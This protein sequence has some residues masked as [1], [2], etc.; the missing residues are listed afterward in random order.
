MEPF[1]IA[2]DMDGT[3][4]NDKKKI[5]YRTKRYL[6]S[7]PKQGHKIVLASGRPSR[8]LISYHKELK[9]DTP[10][11][12]YNGA[13]VFSLTDNDFPTKAFEFPKEIVKDV[14]LKL[15]PYSLNTMC[16]TD[17]EIWVDRA[18]LYLAKFFWYDNMDIIYG[19]LDKT[20]DKN[21]MTMIVQTPEEVKDTKAIT[22][23]VKDYPDLEIRFWTGS[24]YFELF[25]KNI[26]KG[27]AVKLI[28][29]YYHIPKDRIIVFGDAEND[30]EMFL[31]AGTAVMMSNG[32]QTLKEKSHMESIKD[33]NHNGIYHTLKTILKKKTKAS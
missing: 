25:Y 24:P 27:S 3:L 14:Y 29:D 18:D 1:L 10:L 22:D 13:Y 31:E 5:S 15:K 6:I 12:C 23:I 11:I 7:L 16:E 28:A 21:P 26:S 9:L 17:K 2:F 8:A 33:N 20:L 32:K 30:V 19:E 4:L